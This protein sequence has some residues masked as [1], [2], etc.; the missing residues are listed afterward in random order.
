VALTVL[1]PGHGPLRA[2]L[3]ELAPGPLV[4]PP[5][6]EVSGRLIDTDGGPLAGVRVTLDLAGRYT[7]AARP[8]RTDV[9][10]RFRLR[11]AAP[12]AWT[13]HVS[14]LRGDRVLSVPAPVG[15]TDTDLGDITVP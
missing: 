14:S 8:G 7:A 5:A 9:A 1:A 12:G 15:D 2:D 4:L 6:V 13:L 10:G 3:A 11:D